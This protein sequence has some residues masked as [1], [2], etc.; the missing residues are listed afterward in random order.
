MISLDEILTCVCAQTFFCTVINLLVLFRFKVITC[1]C[2]FKC[3]YLQL[4]VCCKNVKNILKKM[5]AHIKYVTEEFLQS[6]S[7]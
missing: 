2:S 1:L 7:L 6:M 3:A 5:C 4:F